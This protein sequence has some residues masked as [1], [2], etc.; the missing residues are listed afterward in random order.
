MKPEPTKPEQLHT[1]YPTKIEAQQE[2]CRTNKPWFTSYIN[3]DKKF[4]VRKATE[5]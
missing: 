3:G 5:Q 1:Y 2:A 4:S